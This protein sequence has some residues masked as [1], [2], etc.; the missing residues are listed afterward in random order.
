MTTEK[1]TKEDTEKAS[2]L[3]A[4]IAMI[5]KDYGKG[6]IMH[7]PQHLPDIQFIPTG[8]ISL[9][10]AMGGGFPRGRI[11]EVYGPESSGK[12]T[13]VLHAAAE[14]QKA[15]GIVAFIDAEHA[16]DLNYAEAL[17]VDAQKLLISQP[18]TA[19]EALNITDKLVQSGVIDLIV[20]DSVAA[21]IPAA[22]LAGEIGDHHM[23]LQ[24]R[25]MGQALRKLTGVV[26]KTDSTIIFINQL[27]MK[28]GVM[29]GNPE[30]TSGGNALKF[31][32]SQR[33]DIRK[34]GA[35]K[36]GEEIVGQR[37]RVKVVKN[38]VAPPFKE[39]EFS[40][41]HGHG[42]DK[43]VDLLEVCVSKDLITKSGSW[44]S[45]GT[46]RIGQGEQTA[47]QFLKDHPEIF[48][49]LYEQCQE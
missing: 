39:A 9:D 32:A 25:L 19:E 14:C 11:A 40:L 29:F 45:Y 47:V 5:E 35:E 22:E 49:K 33:I 30:T 44:Y 6:A 20:I 46:D 34:T 26:G 18:T 15:G 17:G 7:G 16:L 2:A 31:Y 36:M 24:A 27:R 1:V 23:G 10:K 43:F 41:K 3:S 48:K 28:I 8:C 42:I 21:L 4:V 38:K 12:T 13:L 37:T